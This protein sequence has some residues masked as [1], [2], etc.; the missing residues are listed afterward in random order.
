MIF[1]SLDLVNFGLYAGAQRLELT[2]EPGKPIVLVGGTNGAGKTT[3]LEAFTLCLHGRRALGPRV[4]QE[5]YDEHIRSRIHTPPGAEPA[6]EA[7]V[8]LLFEHVHGGRRSNYYVKRNWRRTRSDRIRETLSITVDGESIDDLTEASHQDFLNSLLPPGLAGF[9]LFDGERIQAL[10]DDEN[11]EH[12]ADAVKRLLGLD[13]IEQLQVDLRRFAALAAK[14]QSHG[15][16]QFERLTQARAGV[17][18]ARARVHSLQ[19]ER[20]VVQARHD[21]LVGRAERIRDRLAR[22][23]G[24]LAAE[25]TELEKE[26]RA[27]AIEIAA[28]EEEMRRLIAGP[29][30]FA[31]AQDLADSLEQRL[32]QEQL[33]EEDE[34]VSRRIAAARERLEQQLSSGS[35]RPVAEVLTALLGGGAIPATPRLHDVSAAERAVLLEHLRAVRD[36]YRADAARI[37]MRVRRAQ[38]RSERAER[39]LLR[40]PDDEALAPVIEELQE[41]ERDV[42]ALCG[43]LARVDDELRKAE[44]ELAVA[45]RE[46]RRAEEV[47]AKDMKGTRS[48]DLALRTVAL[49]DQYGERAEERRLHQVESEATRYFNRLSRKGELLSK[50]VIDRESFRVTVVRWDGVEL[51]KERLSAGEKQL[52]AIALLWALARASERPLP[53][54]VDTPLARLDREHRRRLLT[55]YLPHVSHQVV[56]LSTDTEVDV[57]AARDLESATARTIYLAHDVETASTRVEEGYFTQDELMVAGDR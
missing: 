33:G 23:G 18:P 10:A 15:G 1:R 47:A 55:E 6:T 11:G 19:D 21:Q 35:D 43:D 49:L 2:P 53:V 52:F 20:A 24:T 50:I 7:S 51:P 22:E 8:G 4:G 12:L 5:R 48:A 31:I 16:A 40:V 37:S 38:E 17:E 39:Q 9:F 30:P 32:L 54:V 56:V 34:V 27:A 44:H 25:R 13:L 46:L 41:T 29:L 42:G 28:A 45:E 57:Q 14:E 3:V 26:A 36:G